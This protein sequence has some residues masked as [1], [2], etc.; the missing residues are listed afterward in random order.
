MKLSPLLAVVPAAIF[1]WAGRASAQ[2][3]GPQIYYVSPDGHDDAAG[4]SNAPL[5]TLQAPAHRART[6]RHRHR[7]SR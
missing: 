7:T 3:V 6:R 5:R 2:P 1:C 4:L